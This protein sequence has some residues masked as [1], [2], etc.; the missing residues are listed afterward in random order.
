MHNIFY[1]MHVYFIYIYK[2][3]IYP[4]F[5]LC[6]DKLVVETTTADATLAFAEHAKFVSFNF[7]KLM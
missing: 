2:H 1:I 4:V 3:I 7:Q 5:I 6:L